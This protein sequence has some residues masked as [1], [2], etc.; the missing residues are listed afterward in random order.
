MYQ[1]TD[2]LELLRQSE[3]LMNETPFMITRCSR[4]LR[5]VFVSRAYAE[6]A[7]REPDEIKG[8]RIVEI[9]GEE[10]FAT[11][12]PY[13]NLVLTGAEVEYE[14]VVT[15][16]GVGPRNLHVGCNTDLG[17]TGHTGGSS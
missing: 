14:N 8:R 3:R 10:G 13:V 11:I 17:S 4:D 1:T 16:A 9:M 15:F 12:R 7:G 5:Y 6:M 2:E